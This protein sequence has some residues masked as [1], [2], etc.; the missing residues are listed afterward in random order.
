MDQPDNDNLS[1]KNPGWFSDLLEYENRPL[2]KK[3][4]IGVLM[5]LAVALLFF[6]GTFLLYKPIHAKAPIGT[7]TAPALR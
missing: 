6:G 1:G 2:S 3:L 7:T 4:V 5:G